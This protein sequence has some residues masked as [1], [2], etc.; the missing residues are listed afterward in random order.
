[1]VVMKSKPKAAKPR[2][3][4]GAKRP[5][6]AKPSAGGS[7]R[8]SELPLDLQIELRDGIEQ[9]ER[10]EGLMDFDDAMAEAERLSDEMLAVLDRDTRPAE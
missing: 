9:A 10:G 1:M 7:W 6:A 3:R 5:A 8:M 2:S 4:R